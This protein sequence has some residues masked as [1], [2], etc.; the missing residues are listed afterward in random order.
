MPFDMQPTRVTHRWS[1][2]STSKSLFIKIARLSTKECKIERSVVILVP[3]MII[4]LSFKLLVDKVPSKNYT[5]E[6]KLNR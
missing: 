4:R 2:V 3:A 1:S 5:K 6:E